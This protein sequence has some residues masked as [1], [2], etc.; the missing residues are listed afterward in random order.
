MTKCIKESGLES[1]AITPL[2]GLLS[3]LDEWAE[4]TPPRSTFPHRHPAPATN[5]AV[6]KGFAGCSFSQA[7]KIA[8]LSRFVVYLKFTDRKK[9]SFAPSELQSAAWVISRFGI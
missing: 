9:K 2:T 1:F 8:Q 3:T 4:N 6:I 5:S 7:G